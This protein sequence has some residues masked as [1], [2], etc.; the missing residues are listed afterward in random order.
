[1]A[2]ASTIPLA[3]GG[4]SA[5]SM[6]RVGCSPR[7]ERMIPG[8][9]GHWVLSGALAIESGMRESPSMLTLGG[10]QILPRE[11]Q[12]G[13][14][15]RQAGRLG[16]PEDKGSRGDVRTQARTE[17]P[18]GWTMEGLRGPPSR[19]PISCPPRLLSKGSSAMRIW[20]CQCGHF[21]QSLCNRGRWR[22]NIAQW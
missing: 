2:G 9:S 20:S 16:H 13:G 18:L 19:P 10:I 6:D 14:R 3:S 22:W 17:A 1:M 12:S 4:L 8:R 7:A 11:D 5:S 15:G 21:G